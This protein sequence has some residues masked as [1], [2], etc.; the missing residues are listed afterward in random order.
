MSDTSEKKST[1]ELFVAHLIELRTRLLH[2]VVALL[3]V[4]IGWRSPCC[5]SCP[6][7]HR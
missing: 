5:P 4:F 1:T 7:A 3:L 2:S 6:K